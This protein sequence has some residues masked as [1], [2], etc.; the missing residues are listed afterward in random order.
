MSYV[1]SFR[2]PCGS[3]ILMDESWMKCG[4]LAPCAY[5]VCISACRFQRSPL[6]V[7]LICEPTYPRAQHRVTTV[8]RPRAVAPCIVFRLCPVQPMRGRVPRARVSTHAPRMAVPHGRVFV[9]IHHYPRLFCTLVSSCFWSCRR[10]GFAGFCG[11]CLAVR[12]GEQMVTELC[13]RAR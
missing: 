11:W 3:P 5:V 4:G 7:Q 8:H 6:T 9:F 13:M 10:A 2:R 12:P 1:S